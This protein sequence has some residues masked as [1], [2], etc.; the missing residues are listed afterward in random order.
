MGR[1]NKSKQRVVPT[2][3][4]EGNATQQKLMQT[5]SRKTAPEPMIGGAISSL[6]AVLAMQAN[7]KVEK[8]FKGS[9]AVAHQR[10]NS[11]FHEYDINGNGKKMS[12]S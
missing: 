6:R 7:R 10:I 12:K 5:I 4:D 1:K 9:F 11:V 3:V 2:K 8:S